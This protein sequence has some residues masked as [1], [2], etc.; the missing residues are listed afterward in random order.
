M[1][2]EPNL[3]DEARNRFHKLASYLESELRKL[4]QE[5]VLTRTDWIKLVE[6]SRLSAQAVISALNRTDYPTE[7]QRELVAQLIAQYET[8]IERTLNEVRQ[9]QYSADRIETRLRSA[10]EIVYSSLSSLLS[11]KSIS[12]RQFDNTLRLVKAKHQQV[13]KG[14]RSIPSNHPKRSELIE[15]WI[16]DYQ[17]D[18]EAL[19]KTFPPRLSY[20]ATSNST[21]SNKPS[22]ARSEQVHCSKEKEDGADSKHNLGGSHDHAQPSPD[23]KR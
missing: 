14:I 22:A 2:D 21:Q 17:R 23:Q 4:Y 12:Q 18:M 1:T 16:A 15:T 10:E 8:S 5:G 7:M 19:A 6:D 13:M 3:Y 11:A 20:A 9:R